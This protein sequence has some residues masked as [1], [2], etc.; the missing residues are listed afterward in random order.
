ME[1]HERLAALRRQKGLSQLALAEKLDVSRQA[2]SKWESG[3]SAPST[4][5]L[6]RLSGLYGVPLDA[7]VNCGLPLPEPEGGPPKRGAL[8]RA[9]ES[10]WF[11]ISFAALMA[12]A[13]VCW[14]GKL[15][16]AE[17]Y[18]RFLY[19]KEAGELIAEFDGGGNMA[20]TASLLPNISSLDRHPDFHQLPYS[21][22]ASFHGEGGFELLFEAVC[23][24][25]ATVDVA[26]KAGRGE[27]RLIIARGQTA[28]E[29]V[30][31][32]AGPWTLR[33]EPGEYRFF[34]AVRR[35]TGEVGLELDWPS[36]PG[37]PAGTA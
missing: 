30:R 36:R 29:E 18:G 33:L 35:Y 9:T 8:V 3:R 24:E 19:P 37:P 11:K 23:L 34:L 21:Y 4:E 6:L 10:Q 16:Q 12:A 2:V 22:Q 28:V 7:L 13:L 15:Y 14:G 27:A 26:H 20:A 31:L 32:D 1:L 25:P 5:N 17:A